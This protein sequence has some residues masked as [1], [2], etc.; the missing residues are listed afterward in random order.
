MFI[1]A[2]TVPECLP[3]MSRQNAQL[4]L[5]VSSTPRVAT[6]NPTMALAAVGAV[7]TQS[8]PVVASRNP[9]TPGTRRDH[10][11]IGEPYSASTMRPAIQLA[12][13]PESSGT[14]AYRAASACVSPYRSI[15]YGCIH[16]MQ[17]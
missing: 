15:R 13:A 6:A 14:I 4:G 8:T 7:E 10:E 16:E 2:D 12:P 1:V 17:M 5:I 3:P 11:R 9:I